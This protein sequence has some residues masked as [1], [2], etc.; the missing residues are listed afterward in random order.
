M[1]ALRIAG[2]LLLL[3]G[4]ATTQ[5]PAPTASATTPCPAPAPAA[6]T[7]FIRLF[8]GVLTLPPGYVFEGNQLGD[9]TLFQGATGAVRIGPRVELSSGYLDFA[10]HS[11]KARE[12]RCGLEIL[13][14]GGDDPPLWLLLG[15]THYALL[16]DRDPARVR[17]IIDSYCASLPRTSATP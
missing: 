17:A 10:Q 11:L 2:L 5:L 4:C 16:Y 6:G 14:H 8:D 3:T 15:K 13:R 1:R 12:K 9:K 7:V